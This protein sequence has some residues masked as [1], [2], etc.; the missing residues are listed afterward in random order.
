M[1]T[2]SDY[3]FTPKENKKKDNTQMKYV[4]YI[5]D[6]HIKKDWQLIK[7]FDH[8]NNAILCSQHLFGC[9]MEVIIRREHE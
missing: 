1:V 4:V 3:N 5:Y 2:M 8:L 9:G 7:E 6:A